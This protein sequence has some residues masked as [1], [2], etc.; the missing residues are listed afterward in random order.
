[1]RAR[2]TVS[3]PD[4]VVVQVEPDL[5][6]RL[7]ELGRA[8]GQEVAV[9]ADGVFVEEALAVGAAI[10]E[11][12]REHFVLI[13][14]LDQ[15]CEQVMHDAARARPRLGFHRLEVAVLGQPRVG[16]VVD[17]Q[18]GGVRG[19]DMRLGNLDDEIR[20][21]DVPCLVVW[22]RRR[23]RQVGRVAAR[24]AGVG[25]RGD[26]RDLFVGQRRVVL[27]LLDADVPLDVPRRH[28]A[29]AHAAS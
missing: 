28:D 22:E 20:R 16:D 11:P 13:D 21:A 17:P 6:A 10:V 1:M 26:R 27:E 7:H 14:F 4:G 15:I 12:A 23:R 25:P 19:H 3:V 18:V 2:S 29:A 5:R 8:V 9:L 24:R